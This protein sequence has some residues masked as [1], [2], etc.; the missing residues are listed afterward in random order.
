MNGYGRE[1]CINTIYAP[2]NTP[3]VYDNQTQLCMND[4]TKKIPE[5]VDG[6]TDGSGNNTSGIPAGNESVKCLNIYNSDE[7]K[8]MNYCTQQ[9]NCQWLDDSKM[10]VPAATEENFGTDQTALTPN[11]RNKVCL[12]LSTDV[13]TFEGYHNNGDTKTYIADADNKANCNSSS[14][15]DHTVLTYNR[16]LNDVECHD[17]DQ[18]NN[19]TDSDVD[20]L[21]T[22]IH[23]SELQ[24]GLCESLRTSTTKKCAFYKDRR[25][26]DSNL[27]SKHQQITKCMTLAEAE[28]LTNGRELLA[29]YRRNESPHQCTGENY[30]W[31]EGENKL[32]FNVGEKCNN[33]KHERICN[34]HSGCIWQS[35][36]KNESQDNFERGFC[37]DLSHDLN[38]LEEKLDDI[39]YKHVQNAVQVTDLETRLV[40]M[41]P[42]IKNTISNID[43]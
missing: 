22:V 20:T 30:I 17:I 8:M 25:P 6:Q 3:C 14:Q 38:N 35:L 31:S 19:Y 42:E 26:I 29:M 1:Q 40:K 27:G 5:V 36:G 2:N 4:D 37:R 23:K 9:P 43:S 16:E 7:D 21:N 12:S 39:H 32:C 28:Q 11:N 33:I 18:I 15:N 10:C 34:R 41:M 24:K 13:D